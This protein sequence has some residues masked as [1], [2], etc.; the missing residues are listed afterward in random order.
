MTALWYAAANSYT[1]RAHSSAEYENLSSGTPAFLRSSSCVEEER[2][3]RNTGSSS[4]MPKTKASYRRLRF[5]RE[6]SMLK[7]GSHPRQGASSGSPGDFQT[8]AKESSEE[9]IVPAVSRIAVTKSDGASSD[10]V[11]V[12]KNDC[13]NL[14]LPT[15]ADTA[16]QSSVPR[17][18]CSWFQMSWERRWLPKVLENAKSAG[19]GSRTAHP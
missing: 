11:F 18:P 16:I 17:R 12:P 5:S 15:I 1:V 3:E 2:I 8:D 9:N 10:R 6:G 7:A 13:A 19:Y 14:N 4:E